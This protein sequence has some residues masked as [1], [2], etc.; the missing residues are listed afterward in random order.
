MEKKK[1]FSIH[2]IRLK[3]DK[4]NIEAFSKHQERNWHN[5]IIQGWS[6]NLTY[7]LMAK[8]VFWPKKTKSSKN[9][10]WRLDHHLE[11]LCKRNEVL[12]FCIVL[13]YHKPLWRLCI[14]KQVCYSRWVWNTNLCLK[15]IDQITHGFFNYPYLHCRVVAAAVFESLWIWFED[16]VVDKSL[17]ILK[18]PRE[19]PL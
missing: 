9:L 11:N 1:R 2:I 3:Q 14:Y 8:I 6:W 7:S 12:C 5:L 17:T 10:R 16:L 4:G 19:H 18:A 13:P 15:L